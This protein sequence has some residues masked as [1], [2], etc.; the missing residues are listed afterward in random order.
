MDIG[1]R[2]TI[3]P[4]A[5]LDKTYPAGVHIG[6]DT[7][8]DFGAVI[9]THDFVNN[10]HTE[11]R[12]GRMCHIGA[13]AIIMPGVEVGDHSIV[14]VASVV[15]KNVPPNSVVAGNPA[16]VIESGIMTGPRGRKIAVEDKPAAVPVDQLAQTATA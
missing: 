8:V 15:M 11:T 16:R 10:G 2:A 5:I 14:A 12:I 3:S 9:L 7:S 4:K 1:S 6:E 13:R